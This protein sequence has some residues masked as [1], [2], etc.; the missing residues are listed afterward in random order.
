MKLLSINGSYRGKKGFTNSC[1]NYIFE[2]ARKAG[3]DCQSVILSE[4]KIIDCTACERCHDKDHYLK[5]INHDIDDIAMIFNKMKD[6]DIIIFATPVYILTMSGLFKKFI[7]R[8]FSAGNN[9]ILCLAD[10]GLLFHHID[11]EI[12]SK[13][14]VS[15]VCGN[16]LEEAAYSNTINYFKN[17]SMFLDAKQVAM[18]VRKSAALFNNPINEMIKNKTDEV[19]KA[20]IDA[21]YELAVTGKINSATIKRINMNIIPVPKL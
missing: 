8:Y 3:A 17:Y 10:N 16:N 13:P 2:G 5:C 7:D 18:L 6:A 19:N 20:F 11:K 1:I 12:F 4:M 9:N 14:F 21:G 15:L